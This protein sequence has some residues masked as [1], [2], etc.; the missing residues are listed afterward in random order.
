MPII[1]PLKDNNQRLIALT[2]NLVFY[3]RTKH[4]DIQ[5]HYIR[6]EVEAKKIEL[7]Y[8]PTDEIIADGFTKT[9]TYVKLYNFIEQMKMT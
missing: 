3:S 2:H 4:I 1:I 5:H 8:I 7:S 6:N 9:L